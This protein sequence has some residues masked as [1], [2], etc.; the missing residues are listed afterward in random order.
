MYVD[1]SDIDN[2]A[3]ATFASM[4]EY[5]E[6]DIRRLLYQA[7]QEKVYNSYY[8]S[9]YQRT[10]SLKNN[11]VIDVD[12][13]SGILYALY[14]PTGYFSFI[15]GYTGMSSDEITDNVPYWVNVGHKVPN[16][17]YYDATNYIEYAVDL[18]ENNLGFPV[19][20]YYNI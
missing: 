10:D 3:K 7:V 15:P 13:S 5:Y 6:N 8:P 4:M 14:K 17:A 9:I 11:I 16:G 18:I 20:V 12:T 1:Y 2:I 19:E